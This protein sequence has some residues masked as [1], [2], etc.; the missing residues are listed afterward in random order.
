MLIRSRT[1][2]STW[3]RSVGDRDADAC[4]KPLTTDR[5]GNLRSLRL[6]GEEY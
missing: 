2:V 3:T 1:R 6:E 4:V 5:I